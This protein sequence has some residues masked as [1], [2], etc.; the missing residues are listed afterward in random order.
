MQAWI[1]IDIFDTQYSY[2]LRGPSET[3][4]NQIFKRLFKILNENKFRIH[5]NKCIQNWNSK[6]YEYLHSFIESIK[7]YC[8]EIKE[9]EEENEEDEEENEEDEDEDDDEDDDDDKEE[10][11]KES[12]CSNIDCK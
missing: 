9:D 1:Y 12:D 6:K 8:A 3:F 10:N 2:K 7:H 4:T 11:E 5:Q